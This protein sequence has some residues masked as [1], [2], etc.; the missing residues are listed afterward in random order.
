MDV[1]ALHK[2]ELEFELACRGIS[3]CKTVATM[4]KFLREIL[5]REQSGE[6]TISFKVPKS[7]ID[8]P[9]T[10]IL[11]CEKKLSAIISLISEVSHSPEHSFFRR[12]HSRLTHLSN[13]A[14]LIIPSESSDIEKHLTL[15]KNI[16]DTLSSLRQIEQE[17]D[18]WY[19]RTWCS[20]GRMTRIGK[21]VKG[22][23]GN[24]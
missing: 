10:E 3:D 15:L 6:S 14:K 7:C 22:N 24:T 1:N 21:S 16:Q 19:K 2:D 11:I 8:N 5:V 9:N 4:R 12:I 18:E 23:C 13:R 20:L 17:E